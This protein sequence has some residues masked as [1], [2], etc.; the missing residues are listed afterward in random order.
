MSARD[1]LRAGAFPSR[2]AFVSATLDEHAHHPSRRADE[3]GVVRGARRSRGS[4][5]RSRVVVRARAS[6]APRIRARS[7]DIH[8]CRDVQ[9]RRC[10]GQ[11]PRRRVQLQAAGGTNG[12]W[13]TFSSDVTVIFHV[14]S[15]KTE[16]A[17][18]KTIARRR[19]LPPHPKPPPRLRRVFVGVE[20]F[21]FHDGGPATGWENVSSNN[22]MTD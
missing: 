7:H 6:R 5:T 3:I 15:H 2:S 14:F 13:W 12:M 16:A 21:G 4:R 19:P 11:R 18:A 8:F 17:T 22:K 20:N 10:G 9:L 1:T